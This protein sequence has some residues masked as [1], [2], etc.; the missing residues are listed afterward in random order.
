MTLDLRKPPY[1]GHAQGGGMRTGL[2]A[3]AGVACPFAVSSPSRAL[4]AGVAA[5]P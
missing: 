1:A 4:R 3:I 5:N 2:C